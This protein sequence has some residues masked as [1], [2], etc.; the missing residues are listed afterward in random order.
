M[1]QLGWPSDGE[2][3]AMLIASHDK[4][5]RELAAAKDGWRDEIYKAQTDMRRAE[6]M[7][8]DERKHRAEA[9]ADYRCLAELLD[10][11]DATECRANLVKLKADLASERA[12]PAN[13]LDVHA[14]CDQRDKAVEDLHRERALAD[15]LAGELQWWGD[16]CGDNAPASIDLTLAAWKEA[17]Q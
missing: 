7:L 9:Q 3:V 16:Y 5:E 2:P 13:L 6:T 4:L 11:H 12:L 10:G 14:I 17:R 1:A 8:N 15:R